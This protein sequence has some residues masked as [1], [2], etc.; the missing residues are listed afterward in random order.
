MRLHLARQRCGKDTGRLIELG[1]LASETIDAL[2][3]EGD[4]LDV[5]VR[6]RAGKGELERPL[7]PKRL[8]STL[9]SLMLVSSKTFDTRCF[10]C[11]RV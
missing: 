10:A 4:T 8:A 3:P 5:V 7:T 6:Q 2:E 11:V 9:G 1:D